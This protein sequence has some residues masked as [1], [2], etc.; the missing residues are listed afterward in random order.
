M[1]KEGIILF[2]MNDLNGAIAEILLQVVTKNNVKK[3]VECT[4][5]TINSEIETYLNE[6]GFRSYKSTY[7]IG[8]SFDKK[9][10]DRI[11]EI[12][13]EEDVKF[14]Y[15]DHHYES[16]E[17]MKYFWGRVL[18]YDANSNPISSSKNLY[19]EIV[20]PEHSKYIRLSILVDLSNAVI[21]GYT[22]QEDEQGKDMIEEL[23]RLAGSPSKFAES[24]INKIMNDDAFFNEADILAKIEEKRKEEER[25]EEERRLLKEKFKKR[26]AGLW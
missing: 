24:M 26:K 8:T 5:E 18:L 1:S 11:T 22:P 10:A 4:E 6:E 25:I 13:E 14:I 12:I 20:S 3:I 19:R 9:L 23:Y 7:I 21:T 17:L 2:R 16:R 15:R